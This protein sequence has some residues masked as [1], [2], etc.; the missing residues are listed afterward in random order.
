MYLFGKLFNVFLLDVYL[1][2]R[3]TFLRYIYTDKMFILEY[4]K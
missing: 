4:R 2:L 1:N 3:E